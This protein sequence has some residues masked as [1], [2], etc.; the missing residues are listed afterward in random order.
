MS[1]MRRRCSP[2]SVEA[3]AL[4]QHSVHPSGCVAVDSASRD[5]VG[6]L[7]A[8]LTRKRSGPQS[9]EG[10]FAQTASK[11]TQSPRKQDVSRARARVG[12]VLQPSPNPEAN[13]LRNKLTCRIGVTDRVALSVRIRIDATVEPDGIGLGVDPARRGFT[14]PRPR[15][16]ARTHEG[17]RVE[18][19]VSPGR[20]RDRIEGHSR[21][22]ARTRE[23]LPAEQAQGPQQHRPCRCWRRQPPVFSS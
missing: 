16:R 23:A 4:I 22:R 15:H 8:R 9:Q 2:A 1:C 17:G 7:K 5:A 14:V 19:D 18:E 6:P 10:S 11:C 3:A 13:Q 21:A 12:Q 20:L